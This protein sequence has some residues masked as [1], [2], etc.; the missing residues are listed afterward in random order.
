[1]H[2]LCWNYPCPPMHIHW[3]EGKG[4]SPT[5]YLRAL[6]EVFRPLVLHK[7]HIK[8]LQKIG[9]SP[10]NLDLLCT[11]AQRR[12][13]VITCSSVSH[14]VMYTVGPVIILQV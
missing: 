8:L 5:V 12:L 4:W 9:V 10:Q 11:Y 3:L 1:M 14:D 2:P 13:E 6:S 7:F